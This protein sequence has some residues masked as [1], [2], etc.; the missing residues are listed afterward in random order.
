MD[1]I[2]TKLTVKLS[3]GPADPG[4]HWY[5]CRLVLRAPIAVNVGQTIEGVLHMVANERFSYNITLTSACTTLQWWVVL[6]ARA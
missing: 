5:Q 4:T 6:C 1:F 3:T 2:G